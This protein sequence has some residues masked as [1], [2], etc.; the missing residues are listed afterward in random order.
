M[1]AFAQDRRPLVT[2]PAVIPP[3][4]EATLEA[5]VQALQAEPKDTKETILKAPMLH[6]QHC[7][8]YL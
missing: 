5:A 8:A 2:A 1:L 3:E 4:A 6:V 7:V